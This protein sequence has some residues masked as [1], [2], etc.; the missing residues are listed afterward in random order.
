MM[1]SMHDINGESDMNMGKRIIL[2][3]NM[4]IDAYLFDVINSIFHKKKP[5]DIT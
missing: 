4:A 2:V 5:G 3:S 1:D